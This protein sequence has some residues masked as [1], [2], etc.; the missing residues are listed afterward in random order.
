MIN[1]TVKVE[2]IPLTDE[3]FQIMET[4]LSK[5]LVCKNDFFQQFGGIKSLNKIQNAWILRND[6]RFMKLENKYNMSQR[7]WI[8]V[9]FDVCSN[10]KSYWS[11]LANF[12]KNKIRE[13]GNL[14]DDDRKYLYYV[15]SA[16]S[17]WYYIL[18]R[19]DIPKKTD[20]LKKL[21][22]GLNLHYLHNYLRR[23]TRKYKYKVPKAKSL[24]CIT[25]DQEMYTIKDVDKTSFISFIT[26]IK[27]KRLNIKL[28]SKYC[29]SRKGNIQLIFNR[30]KKCIEIHKLISIKNKE[31]TNTAIIGADKGYETLLS[32]SDGNEYG[33]GLGKLFTQEAN[34][35]DK[36][37]TNRNYFIQKG[38]KLGN[39]LY[40]KKHKRAKA[41]LEK[42]INVA[43]KE[44]IKTSKPKILVKE[45][46]L[47]IINHKY[48]GKEFNRKMS[49]WLNGVLD[50][51][52]EYLCKLYSIET[53]DINP[54]YTSQY[55]NKCKVH[56]TRKGKHN[57]I[58]VCPNCGEIN[59][60]VNASKNIKEIYFDNEINLYT[61]YKKVKEILDSRIN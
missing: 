43:I 33:K 27:G 13:N 32:C 5:C 28:K 49:N 1:K 35:L 34:R 7:L 24:R 41:T 50:K 16:Q 2:S 44:M 25:L 37:N 58:G 29:Y 54:A 15:L 51:R 36:R 23:I 21:E 22:V 9:L 10:L 59:A 17:I 4:M 52:I 57:E 3:E 45:E 12:L 46:L 42:E 20:K 31:N 11:N 30:D 26:D 38:I 39:K 8:M 55:C 53:V 47:Q 6:L 61:P 19:I 56:I 40:Y 48:K 18:N 60:N 14:T